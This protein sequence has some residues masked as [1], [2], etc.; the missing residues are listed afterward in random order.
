M[1]DKSTM[2]KIENGAENNCFG[3]SK[4]NPHGLHMEFIISSGKA[5]GV[6]TPGIYHQGWPGITHGGILF[7]LLDEVGGY[8]VRS[9]GVDCVTARCETRFI[10]PAFTGGALKV[11]ATVVRKTSRTVETEASLRRDDGTPVAFAKSLWYIVN[12]TSEKGL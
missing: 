7:C 5:E 2:L 3:C 6:F 4:D 9:A 8:A 10:N 12:R 11:S 1:N